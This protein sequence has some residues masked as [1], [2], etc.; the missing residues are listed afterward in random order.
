MLLC[1]ANILE[2][3]RKFFDATIQK[4]N[5]VLLGNLYILATQ[6]GNQRRIG[7]KKIGTLQRLETTAADKKEQSAHKKY[8]T[9]Y[10]H[11]Y[12]NLFINHLYSGTFNPD[13]EMQR[14]KNYVT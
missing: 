4:F 7:T 11:F 1:I 5:I 3:A 10:R 2:E 9:K 6:I 8:I 13:Y 14:Y 12:K